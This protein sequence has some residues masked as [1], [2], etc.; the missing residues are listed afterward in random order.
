MVSFKRNQ[1][2]GTR[3]SFTAKIGMS[4]FSL[5]FLGM[6]LFFLVMLMAQTYKNIQARSWQR[7]PCVISRSSVTTVSDGYRFDVTYGYRWQGRDYSSSQYSIGGDTT[8]SDIQD[9]DALKRK[10]REGAQ[11]V[12]YVNPEDP[13]QAVLTHSSFWIALFAFLPLIFVLVGGGLLY[14]TWIPGSPAKTADLS[15]KTSSSRNRGRVAGAIF[16]SLFFFTGLAVGVFWIFPA[17]YKSLSSDTWIETPCQILSSRVQSHSD[18]DGTT[19]SVDISYT[20]TVGGVQYR[21][22]RYGFIG[23]S[24]S[25]YQ[26]KAAVVRRYPPGSRAVCYINPDDPSEAVLNTEL[27]WGALLGLIPVVFMTVGLAGGFFMIRKKDTSGFVRRNQAAPLRQAGAVRYGGAGTAQMVLRPKSSRAGKIVGSIC[28]A[29]FWNGIVSIFVYQAWQGWKHN[30]PE[31]F[32]ILFLIPFVLVGLGMIGSIFY[33]SLAALN[34]V[35]TV[36]L[37]ADSVALGQTIRL[38]WQ[39]SGNVYKLEQFKLV[40]TGEEVATYRR[41]T[42]SYTDHN[43]FYRAVVVDELDPGRMRQGE[44]S[45]AVPRESMHSF[46]GDHNQVVWKITLHGD[47]PRWP[48]IKEEFEIQVHP[49]PMEGQRK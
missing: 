41:G 27:G 22:S 34:P 12:C 2:P 46:A 23:G 40:F 6:G 21:S 17:I 24:S 43:T 5:V 33:F 49:L 4:L 28:I 42:T 31:Y 18:S 16:F 32:L 45:L 47:I 29:V 36:I 35:P 25:G 20:Y 48:D 44:S 37:L 9:A 8:Q 19:Y 14:K 10:Y 3:T 15:P 30:S 7:T 38:R 39:I 13:R 11:H 1:P 26:G